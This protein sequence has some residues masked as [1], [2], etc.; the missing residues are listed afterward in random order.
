MGWDGM[1][2]DEMGWDGMGWDGM[3]WGFLSKQGS[4]DKL[5]VSGLFC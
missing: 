1:G 3:G 4:E 2:W 5:Q